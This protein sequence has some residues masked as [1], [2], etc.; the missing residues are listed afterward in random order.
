M[1]L[2]NSSKR[3]LSAAFLQ[4]RTSFAEVARQLGVRE[5]SVR[6]ALSHLKEQG[7]I[8]VFP[9][10]NVHALGYTDYCMFLSLE[11]KSKTSRAQL[12]E[13]LLRSPLT[14]WVGELGGEFQ[15]TASL[16]T[17]NVSELDPFLRSLARY[18]KGGLVEKAFAIRLNWI[19]FRPK[20]LWSGK[21]KIETLNRANNV[22]FAEI[23]KEDHLLLRQMAA[24]PDKNEAQLARSLS[25]PSTTCG[26]RLRRLE[27]KGVIVGYRYQY[28][29]S[30]IG[31][32]CYRLLIYETYSSSNLVERLYKYS[33]DHENITGFVR[34]MGNWDY[35]IHVEVSSP[36]Q[37][38][39][40]VNDIYDLFGDSIRTIRTLSDVAT[41]KACTYPFARD[42]RILVE[43][44]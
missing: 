5:H 16:F 26:Y 42:E 36:R 7:V 18:S 2:S 19:S 39:E 28:D 11:P 34:C 15:Y 23:D 37:L 25:L 29:P 41:H 20:Y 12:L 4:A 13:F 17:R 10:I 24:E 32:T 35:E 6:Q 43:R 8:K 38:P 40:I 44:S 33:V 31:F 9:V 3:I 27:E 1:R 21:A 14:A 22:P 30:L